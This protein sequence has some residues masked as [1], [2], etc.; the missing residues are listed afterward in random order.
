MPAI[1]PEARMNFLETRFAIGAR[2]FLARRLRERRQVSFTPIQAFGLPINEWP[3]A[4][5]EP[6]ADPRG[7]ESELGT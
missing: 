1:F 6:G 5:E 3:P 2:E 4:R 7:R